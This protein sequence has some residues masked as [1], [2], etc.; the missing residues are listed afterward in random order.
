MYH[1]VY[2]T[3]SSSG[4]YYIGRHSTKNLEDGYLGSGKWVRQVKRRELLERHILEFCDSPEELARRE[5]ELIR[6]HIGDDLNMNFNNNS[7]GFAYGELNPSSR[8]DRRR[9]TSERMKKDNPAQSGH[10]EETKQK[11]SDAMQGE[12][13]PFYGKSHSEETKR[14]IGEKTSQKVWTEE[15]R[16]NLSEVRKKQFNGRRPPYLIPP[17]S[18]SE[19]SKKLVSQAALAR[20]KTTCPHCGVSAKPHTYKRW[21]GDR[22]KQYIIRKAELGIS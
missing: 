8:P 16:Q 22:C 3:V 15:E 4:R 9:A 13:N 20:P 21:H 10:S 17:T 19:E 7:V 2:K 11:I 6:E 12:K 5:R 1:F 14:A 18:L